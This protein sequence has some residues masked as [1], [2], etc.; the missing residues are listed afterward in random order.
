MIEKYL[1]FAWEENMLF[2]IDINK[3]MIVRL[4]KK[5]LVWT[6]LI[7]VLAGGI[8][9]YLRLGF[10]GVST[11]YKSSG[12][13]VQ[14]D[15]N[16]SLITSYQ[17]FV[18]SKR[19]TQM[20]DKQVSK[21]NWKEKTDNTAY[22]VNI[23]TDSTSNSPF[24]T[25]NVVSNNKQYSSYLTNIAMKLLMA[26]IGKYLSGTNISIVSNAS[27]GTANTSITEILKNVWH[28]IVLGAAV[29]S[30]WFILRELF[31]GRI[32]DEGYLCDVC[33][34]NNLGTIEALASKKAGN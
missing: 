20:I 11:T 23:D 19:F 28:G 10:G 30:L 5:Y 12:E 13:L 1:W 6:V 22:T 32:K 21:G 31:I 2:S 16:Y 9:A 14:N 8:G 4:L 18:K 27:V 17:Q 33:G 26:N 3:K 24:F 7:G 29:S 15:N 34:I 25:I